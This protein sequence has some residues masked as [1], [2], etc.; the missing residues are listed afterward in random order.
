V[1]HNSSGHPRQIHLAWMALMRNV[2]I[3]GIVAA[4]EA[5]TAVAPD[6][7]PMEAIMR[8][9]AAVAGRNW[10]TSLPAIGMPAAA[11]IELTSTSHAVFDGCLRSS[12]E[13]FFE[14]SLYSRGTLVGRLTFNLAGEDDAVATLQRLCAVRC[15]ELQHV[16]VA[17]SHRGQDGGRL[18]MRL[19]LQTLAEEEQRDVAF[20]ALQH[21]DRN[22][23]GNGKVGGLVR[24]Y[25]SMGFEMAN[26][27]M[28]SSGREKRFH[29]KTMVASV[30]DLRR[31]LDGVSV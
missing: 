27:V 26:D 23:V 10:Q 6:A 4:A 29:V 8:K 21:D 25:R 15:A 24:W 18:L 22:D 14:T 16:D 28:P 5:L 11:T 1:L 13:T 30:A 20:V 12:K 3:L 2:V 9:R 31:H 19:M 7:N 17:E